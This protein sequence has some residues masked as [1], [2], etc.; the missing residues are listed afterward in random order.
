MDDYLIVNFDDKLFQDAF[1]KYFEE[2][3]IQVQNWDG[4]W[5]EMNSDEGTKAFV[6]TDGDGSII[7]FIMFKIIQLSNWFFEENLGFVREFW[8][9]KEYRNGGHGTALLQLAEDYFR[10]NDIQKS[11]LTTD[12]AERFYEK[13]GYRKDETYVAKNEDDVFVKYL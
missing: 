9:A 13:H 3:G 5:A 6:R 2:L 10:E 12:T 4:L 7:G 8:I 11:I 1:K